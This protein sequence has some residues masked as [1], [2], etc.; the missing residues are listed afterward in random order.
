MERFNSQGIG[1]SELL[2]TAKGTT[3]HL[4]V[5]PEQLA[6]T[7][8]TVGDPERVP[9]IS[10]YFDKISFKSQ[11]REFVC[12]GGY[13]GKKYLL[14]LSTGIGP[15]NIDIVL[16]ELDALANI[17]FDTKQINPQHRTLSIIRLGT[18]GGLQP[19]VPTGSL[20]TSSFAI[21]MDNL[22]LYYVNDYNTDER[23]VLDSF[24]QHTRLTDKPVEPYIA[25]GS[26]VLRKHFGAGYTNGI[27]VTTPGFYGPQG[28]VTRAQ[29]RYPYLTD[30]FTS[31]SSRDLR[32]LNYEME[33]AAL[34]ALGK[35]LGHLCLSISTVINNRANDTVSQQI[36]MDID[37][38][39]RNSLQ[40]IAE[41]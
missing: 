35:L 39:I 3:Y 25:E 23:F 11:H 18:C 14:V 37:N 22:M 40:I 12:H 6:E 32:I 8:I 7:I 24:M 30:A 36:E 29:L 13:I 28:R 1:H 21:G 19:D 34:Y 41:I 2:I 4:P 38:M 9:M 27:T 16:T 26:I 31:F 10:R 15:D 33:T 20:I 5:K 17:N